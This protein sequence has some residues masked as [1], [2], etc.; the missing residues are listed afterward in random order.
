M[1]IRKLPQYGSPKDGLVLNHVKQGAI[2]LATDWDRFARSIGICGKGFYELG[3]GGAG[4]NHATAFSNDGGV[5]RLFDPELGQYSQVVAGGPGDY[6]VNA[7]LIP[8]Y[9]ATVTHWD[10][11]QYLGVPRDALWLHNNP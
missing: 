10:I 4:W 1:D 7:L 3:F 6:I 11:W 2:G 9:G 5:R 8:T